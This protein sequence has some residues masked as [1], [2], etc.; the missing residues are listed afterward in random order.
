MLSNLSF[1]P[2]RVSAYAWP[3]P[4]LWWHLLLLLLLYPA[5]FVIDQFRLVRIIIALM[6]S[7]QLVIDLL[8]ALAFLPKNA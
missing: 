3:A 5:A 7:W 2:P 4:D 8:A 6:Q 1:P